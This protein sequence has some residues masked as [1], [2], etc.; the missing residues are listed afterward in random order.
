MKKILLFL[1]VTFSTASYSQLT[2]S[3]F[4]NAINTCLT[5]NPEDGMCTDS[6]Y[7]AMPDWDVSQV[8]DMSDAF[9]DLEGFNADISNWNVSSVTDMGLMFYN[10]ESFNQPIGNWNVSNVTTMLG[11]FSGYNNAN[12][13]SFNQPIGNW[14]VS[15]VNDM[16]YMFLRTASFNQPIGNWDVGN[17]TTMSAMFDDALSFNQP[18]GNWDVGNVTTMYAM[19][20]GAAAFN[21]PIGG[22][23]VSNVTSIV[24]LFSDTP[25]NHPIGN[26]DVSNVTDMLYTFL[27][28]YNF[29]QDLSNWDVSNVTR[30]T[31]TFYGAESFN[32]DISDWNTS[33]ANLMGSMFYNATNFNQDLS[34]W[35]ISNVGS[36]ESNFS[37]FKRLFTGSNL[38]TEN[39]DNILISWS[40]QSVTQN[41]EF[42]AEGIFYCNSETQRQSLIDNYGWIINDAGYN[43]DTAGI[44][45][46]GI[47]SFSVYP[48]PT[49]NTLFISG[50]ET[51]ITVAIY[52]V[53]GKEV[54]SI[55]NT[56]NINVKALPSGVYV[57]RISDGIGQTNRK[58]IKN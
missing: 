29:N 34:S 35:D 6:E 9:K 16:R 23:N 18:I 21:Q 38:S 50:N 13:H 37:Y 53:L 8:T 17:V 30:F 5:T 12:F 28:A 49:D 26:W 33:N 44:D 51:P 24:A 31:G 32:Q 39:Y 7:G 20:N 54:L 4:R 19:F 58:F 42:D 46:L 27:R 36:I 57:I 48:N 52:N 2:D 45:D 25:F 22:W 43:C 3:N 40:Q 55:K 41:L 56:N 47:T 1:A 10:T 14:D 11:M 15:S